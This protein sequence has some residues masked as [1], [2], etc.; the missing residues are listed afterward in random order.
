[1]KNEKKRILVS[2]SCVIVMLLASTLVSP[3]GVGGPRDG[4][5]RGPGY[6]PLP[7]VL[8]ISPA[9]EN[10]TLTENVSVVFSI[11]MDQQSAQDAF[12][13]TPYIAG[14]FSWVNDTMTFNPTGNYSNSTTYTITI[15]SDTA[16]SPTDQLLDG[17]GDDSSEGS[18]TDDVVW[19][20]TTDDTSPVGPDLPSDN[21]PWLQFHLDWDRRGESNTW[22]EYDSGEYEYDAPCRVDS[23]PIAVSNFALFGDNCGNVIAVKETTMAKEWKRKISQTAAKPTLASDGEYFWVATEGSSTKA[24]VLQKREIEKGK[25]PG[26]R[27]GEKGI[28]WKFKNGRIYAPLTYTP[29]HPFINDRLYV[30]VDYPNTNPDRSVVWSFNR[31]NGLIWKYFLPE[32]RHVEHSGPAMMEPLIGMLPWSLIFGDTG[33]KVYKVPEDGSEDDTYQIGGNP[34]IQTTPACNW[35]IC[36]VATGNQVYEFQ[37][38]EWPNRE[39]LTLKRSLQW[40]MTGTVISSPAIDIGAMELYVSTHNHNEQSPTVYFYKISFAPISIQYI[41]ISDYKWFSTGWDTTTSGK[42]QPS[43]AIGGN[44]VFLVPKGTQNSGVYY[45]CSN[46]I[47]FD[48][49]AQYTLSSGTYFT[50]SSPALH[51]WSSQARAFAGTSDGP[52]QL[53]DET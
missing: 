34:E 20:Y 21:S 35:D 42:F 19:N 46:D 43:A 14:S 50:S 3:G 36:Y 45:E 48:C 15:D 18:P 17:D 53:N 13:I 28:T 5:G 22:I 9:E 11:G 4:G 24:P 16:Q 30:I 52:L 25:Q 41:Y 27:T 23:S 1:M 39:D 51:S 31:N 32:G 40:T 10:I 12:N 26:K 6:G 8:A 29:A 49:A 7:T 38:Y 47:Y 37:A 33:G 2:Y 44:I